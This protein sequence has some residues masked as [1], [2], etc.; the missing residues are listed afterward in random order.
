MSILNGTKHNPSMDDFKTENWEKLT[1]Q[2]RKNSL[3]YLENKVAA[4]EGRSPRKIKVD[5][6]LKDGECG[7]Y[8]DGV[9]NR[10][11]IYINEDYLYSNAPSKQYEAMDTVLHEGRHA[12]QS[13]CVKGRI[14]VHKDDE[15]KLSD[16]KKN[17]ATEEYNPFGNDKASYSY[18]RFQPVEDDANN[19]AKKKMEG[20]SDIYSSD[21]NY[22]NYIE[23][24]QM[25]H[26]EDEFD[27]KKRLGKD[28][29]ENIANDIRDR[30]D[31][32]HKLG[33]Y[34]ESKKASFSSGI[35][36]DKTASTEKNTSRNGSQ[37][38]EAEKLNTQ[39][40]KEIQNRDIKSFQDDISAKK[41]NECG[42][43]PSPENN[44]THKSISSERGQKPSSNESTSQSKGAERGSKPTYGA[45]NSN[46]TTTAR[47]EKPIESS[48]NAS[49]AKDSQRGAPPSS[50][51]GEG[52]KA[53]TSASNNPSDKI[54][55]SS[56]STKAADE[57]AK[58]A[59]ER[60]APKPTGMNM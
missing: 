43:K 53:S 39:N 58:V 24:T 42:S 13:D 49:N 14:E 17:A 16:W 26:A 19:F 40:N 20:Y 11:N 35:S 27:A 54:S 15:A 51:G 7:Y 46:N 18:Y 44:E 52:S 9:F 22:R 2:E 29:K 33:D 21:P 23:T 59:A 34:A 60:T 12:Y 5:K 47:G 57:A 31:Y 28:Y 4:E 10:N 32:R 50:S 3:Q 48:Q 41:S 36:P 37:K 38:N 8:S 55:A 6:T 45:N 1:P 30:Y 25:K 56:N